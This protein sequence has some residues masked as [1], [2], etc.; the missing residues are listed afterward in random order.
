MTYPWAE[1]AITMGY[2][3]EK[4][5]LVEYPG[6]QEEL[7]EELGVSDPGIRHRK[8]RHGIPKQSWGGDRHGP[9]ADR[10]WYRFATADGWRSERDM[11]ATLLDEYNGNMSAVARDIGRLPD[12]VKA[13][14]IKLGLR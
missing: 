9:V 1:Y 3:S 6:T 8:R 7:A 11:F 4:E 10:R 13:R 12:T 2:D 5:M 14:I